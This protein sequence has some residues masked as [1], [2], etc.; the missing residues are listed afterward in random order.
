MS[1]PCKSEQCMHCSLP[2]AK[3]PTKL[4]PI[5]LV[6]MHAYAY[7]PSFGVF[8]RLARK[9]DSKHMSV[10]DRVPFAVSIPRERTFLVNSA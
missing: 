5:G 10:Y 8:L 1:G 6:S 4:A 7:A 3:T 2:I 9:S